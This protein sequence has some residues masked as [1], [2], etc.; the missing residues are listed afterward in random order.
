M[1]E[2]TDSRK[3]SPAMAQFHRWKAEHPG[4][5]LFFQMGDF[6]EMFYDDARTVSR[7]L[8]LTLTSRQKGADAIPMA[9]VPV[10]SA[11]QYLKKLVALGFR[12][13]ICDQVQD[14]KDATLVVDRQVTRIVT[15]G[16]LTEEDLLDRGAPNFLCAVHASAGQRVGLALIDLST[17]EFLVA[18]AA[19]ADLAE[20]LSRYRPAEVLVAESARDPALEAVLLQHERSAVTARP[21]W[22]FERASAREALAEHFRVATLG[23]FGVDDDSPV[24][25]AAGAAL[26]YLAETQKTA[27]AHLNPP[28][29]DAESERLLLDRATRSCLELTETTR[30]G[31]KD[32]SLLFV[33][34]HTVTALGARR[35]RDW[36]FAPLRQV[37]AI[38]RRQAAVEELV[39]DRGACQRL[40][41]RLRGV[42]DVE[43]LLTRVVTNR[44]NARD[45]AGL[46]ASLEAVPALRQAIAEKNAADLRALLERLD[47]LPELASHLRAALVD[48]PPLALREGGMIRDGFSAELDELR[49][50][51]RDGRRFILRYQKEEAERSGIPNLRVGFN[52]VFGFY[53]E[54]TN[55]FRG[56]VP[57]D[58]ARKQTLKNAERYVTPRLKEY[59]AKVLSAEDRSQELEFELFQR[60]RARVLEQLEPV[61]KTAAALAELDALYSLAEV[62]ALHGYTRPLVDDGGALEIEEGRH[63]VLAAT[64]GASQFV[65]NDCRLDGATRRLAI[66]TGPNMAGKSTYIRQVALI[67]ILAQMGGFVPAR[68]ARVS[69]CDRIF[70]RVGASD[71]LARG[72]STFMVEMT[73]TAN[74]LNNAT[75]QSL[76][77]LDEVGR[78][79]STFDG[80]ALAWAISEH[81]LQVKRAR[82]LF[83]THYHQLIDLAAVFTGVVN[84]NVAVREWGE[85]IVFL[86][87]IVEGGSDRSYGIH[88]ARLAGVPRAVL[89]RA[90]AVLADLEKGNPD[91]APRSAHAPRRA[92]GTLFEDPAQALCKEMRGLDPDAMSP[93]DALLKLREW[94]KRFG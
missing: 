31:R 38:E 71:D 94:R 55:S 73:E 84:L 47:P 15:A 28:R 53:I 48:D 89:E 63:P 52:R 9:G 8:G 56:Q 7:V 72:R 6:F 27:L 64:M 77:I 2:Q 44:A 74:I 61:K 82:T 22:Q 62:A 57:A 21:D 39:L 16:T 43:R 3:L 11:D 59:E 10:R 25:E 42:A 18:E 50:I 80:L 26:R 91:L 41:E 30:E 66:V 79:T 90:Q 86:H 4:E 85:E 92:Q 75:A 69:V 20:A 93:L 83:A 32:G 51:H 14:P 29:L 40:R 58:Y 49:G 60:I 5:I 17:G 67:Q 76:V 1:V 70:A 36:L 65:P 12:V 37:A 13:A 46:R 54:V 33:I 88:V 87:R 68:R 78:G 34:D 23:G 35:L 81:L 19:R 45:L 24:V